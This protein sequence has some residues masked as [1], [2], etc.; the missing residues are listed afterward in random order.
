[1]LI[2][3]SDV[4]PADKEGDPVRVHRLGQTFNDLCRVLNIKKLP[5]VDPSLYI[6][7]FAQ[8]LEFG[9]K[10]YVVAQTA[11]KFIQRMN[12][13]WIQ[14]GR[15]PAGICGAALMMAGRLHGFNRT[16]D[17][18]VNIVRVGDKT[19]QKRITEFAKTPSVDLT[20]AQFQTMD[21]HSDTVPPCFKDEKE[22]ED[23][24][25]QGNGKKKRKKKSLKRGKKGEGKKSTNKKKGKK[26]AKQD[27]SE[28]EE[29]LDENPKKKRK[30]NGK[31]KTKK[32]K[33]NKKKKT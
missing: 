31:K 14:T 2:D 8:Q 1:M 10:T 6:D 24:M 3:F 9:N 28:P 22:K 25:D 30:T 16:A 26:S 13:D 33:K 12:R 32:T 11:M 29:E 17:D 23:D 19:L 7:R 4:L 5:L 27:D 20:P 18:I 15:R 21:I